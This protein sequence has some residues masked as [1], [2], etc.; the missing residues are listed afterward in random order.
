MK[1]KRRYLFVGFCVMVLVVFFTAIAMSGDI[2]TIT[3]KV[4]ENYQIVEGDGYG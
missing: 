2:K 3:G 1:R 4:N